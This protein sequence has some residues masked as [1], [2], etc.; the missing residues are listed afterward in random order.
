MPLPRDRDREAPPSRAVH[1]AIWT[2]QEQENERSRLDRGKLHDE[3]VDLRA[4]L[5]TA[6]TR[7]AVLEAM[8]AR[9]GPVS[10]AADLGLDGARLLLS[11][12]VANPKIGVPALLIAGL[13]LGMIVFEIVSD[14]PSTVLA[15]AL[16]TLT[17]GAIDAL[18]RLSP[19]AST[20]AP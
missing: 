7:I 1:V 2:A 9:K 14:S 19:P 18:S 17:H 3:A 4:D 8:T 5:A 10:R 13:M 11:W 6:V 20:P 15:D 12:A 16:I